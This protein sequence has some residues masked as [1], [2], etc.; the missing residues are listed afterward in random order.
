MLNY[1]YCEEMCR[2]WGRIRHGVHWDR[3]EQTELAVKALNLRNVLSIQLSMDPFSGDNTALRQLWHKLSTPK[4]RATNP[5]VR[6]INELRSDGKP[7]YF[8]MQLED[9]KKLM[10]KTDGFHIVDLVMRLNRLLGN[11]ELAPKGVPF[12]EDEDVP[13][14][15]L[16]DWIRNRSLKKKPSDFLI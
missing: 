5:K 13:D 14:N 11:P 16:E 10:F 1:F 6:V 4:V 8:L 7:P 3:K 12:E 2:L 15:E 9:G